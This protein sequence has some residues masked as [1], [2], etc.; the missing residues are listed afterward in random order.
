[1]AILAS[2]ATTGGARKRFW[3]KTPSQCTA[4]CAIFTDNYTSDNI[5]TRNQSS[6]SETFCISKCVLALAGKI[7]SSKVKLNLLNVKYF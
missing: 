3:T 5:L 7:N 6:Q 2:S 4:R 1:M